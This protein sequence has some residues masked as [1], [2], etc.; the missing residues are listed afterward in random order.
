MVRKRMFRRVITLLFAVGLIGADLSAASVEQ[1]MKDVERLR[2][3]T[4]TAT[5]KQRKVER[6]DL[7]RL[8]RE[9][10]AKSL[11]YSIDDYVRILKA[12]QLVDPK[13]PD[14]IGKMLE[15]YQSQVL[16]FYDPHA[17][18]YYAIKDLPPVMKGIGDAEVLQQAI[19]VHEL[20]HALQDQRFH[21]GQREESLRRDSDA[22]MAYHSLVE[23]EASLV[24]MAWMLE[25][26]GQS[27]DQAMKS[28]ATMQWLA[29]SAA[30]D[31]MVDP[32]TPRYFVESLKFPYFMG[33]KLCIEGYRRG[34]WKMIDKM[35]ANPPRSTAE[36]LDLDSYFKRLDGRADVRPAFD[37][38]DKDAL[39]V[40]HLGEFHWRFLAGDK[41]TGW[42]NDRVVVTRAGAVRADTQW[43]TPEHAAAFRDAYV[44]FLRGRGLE[45]R[46]TTDGARVH[47]DYETAR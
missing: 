1:A 26:G 32:S 47:I 27:L 28:D 45:P 5:V 14:L 36:L 35:H 7:P 43:D 29:D 6:S 33:M 2:G 30:G 24:M 44:A 16:A 42:V 25:K 31:K 46:V 20:T 12:L 19:A 11:P 38:T 41:V 8:L 15:L 23:G 21:A 13:T 22:E 10:I 4:F 9:Q 17:H 39:T 34:G 3:V 40:E 37:P 18:V